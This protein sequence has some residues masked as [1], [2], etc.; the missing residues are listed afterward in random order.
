MQYPTVI[1]QQFGEEYALIYSQLQ[2]MPECSIYLCDN[3]CLFMHVYYA[4]M[5]TLHSVYMIIVCSV[6]SVLL[7]ILCDQSSW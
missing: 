1:I 5:Y 2:R 7:V 4:Y 3:A 6:H